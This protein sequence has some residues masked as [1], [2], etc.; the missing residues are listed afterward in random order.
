MEP[1]TKCIFGFHLTYPLLHCGLLLPVCLEGFHFLHLLAFSLILVFLF[2]KKKEESPCRNMCHLFIG[3]L[4]T[5]N[6][7]NT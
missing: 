1:A 5:K 3:Q 2:K 4:A 6:V 7:E